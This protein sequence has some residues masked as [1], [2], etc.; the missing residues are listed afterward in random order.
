MIDI[1][2]LGTILTNKNEL[3]ETENRIIKH[4][5][6]FFLYKRV[7][8]S[9]SRKK[10]IRPLATYGAESWTLNKAIAKWLDAFDRKVLRRMF[11]GIKVNENWRK[12]YNKEL[13]QLL[14]DYICFHLSE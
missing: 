8:Q 9:E 4:M 11:G 10:S 14:G 1:T 2:Y 7:N 12:Q 13:M 3:P 6:H 5:V